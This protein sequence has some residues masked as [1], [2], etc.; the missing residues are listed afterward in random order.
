MY[1]LQPCHVGLQLLEVVNE[2]KPVI[3]RQVFERRVIKAVYGVL[4][5][6][7]QH[8]ALRTELDLAR[9]SIGF[10][11][12]PFEQSIALEPRQQ[13]GEVLATDQQKARQVANR[14]ALS[15]LR[16]GQCTQHRP[17][18][19]GNP[20]FFNRL[21]AF[22]VQSVC[23]LKQPKKQAVVDFVN[24]VIFLSAQVRHGVFAVTDQYMGSHRKR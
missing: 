21:R 22:G 12:S 7:P 5:P 13:A 15:G 18:L 10:V 19:R 17:L 9:A 2:R 1:P 14:H 23:R 11:G 4:K 8:N 20:K 24:S 3:K 16:S 6:R